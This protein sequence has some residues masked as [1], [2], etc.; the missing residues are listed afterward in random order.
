MDRRALISALISGLIAGII[1]SV[2]VLA[3]IHSKINAVNRNIQDVVN[4]GVA[5]HAFG[6]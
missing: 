2:I 3:V 1:A 6:P 5:S 4:E